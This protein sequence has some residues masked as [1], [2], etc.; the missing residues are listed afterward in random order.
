MVAPIHSGRLMRGNGLPLWQQLHHDL[1][2]RLGEG[3]FKG[4]FPGELA[5]RDEYGVSRNTVREALRTMRNEGLVTS[6]RGHRPRITSPSH[7]EQPLGALY[8][9]FASVE[10]AGLE[11]RSAVVRLDVQAD[12]HASVR[13]QREESTPLIRLERIRLA[14]GEPLAHDCVWIPADVGSGLLSADFSHTSLYAELAERCGVRL[15]GG[16]ERLAAVIP[17]AQ[18]R[19]LLALGADTAAFAIERLGCSFGRPVEWRTTLIRADR[20]AAIAEFSAREGYVLNL[21]S[22]ESPRA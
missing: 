5:L 16:R 21:T 8:S 14:G 7:L 17:T 12:A 1:M 11:Q 18:Q 9:L 4:A 19:R 13:L 15:T 3:E 22:S 2:R 20:F 6:A 10:G